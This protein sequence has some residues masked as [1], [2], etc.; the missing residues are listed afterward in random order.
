MASSTSGTQQRTTDAT[1]DDNF[2]KFPP[3]IDGKINTAEFLAAAQGVVRIVDKF[4]K[5]FAP[6]KYDMQGNIDKLN[7]KY[8]ADKEKHSTL[9]DMI[10]LEKISGKTIIATDALL[11]LRRGLHMIQ[12]FF[13]KIIEDHKTGKAS[14]DLVAL[15]KKAYKEALEPYHGW[16]AQQLFGLLSRTVPTRSQLL[17]ALANEQR[18]KDDLIIQELD[19]FLVILKENLQNLL[20]FYIEHNLENG[21]KV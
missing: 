8:V 12:V 15:L 14:D 6:V 7:T 3:V 2:I 21:A 11:W 17:H 9:H 10:L 19:V 16:M 4:G 1:A 5:L 20:T 18:N 13:E